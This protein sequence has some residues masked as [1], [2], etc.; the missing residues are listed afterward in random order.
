[1]STA[2]LRVA[3]IGGGI[4]G[5]TV[6]LAIAKKIEEG[7]NIQLDVYE[8]APKFAEIGAG[9]AF[10]PN[11]QRA[12]RL[13]GVGGALDAVAG[14]P[15]DDANLWFE[16]RVGDSGENSGKHFATITGTD[17]ARGSVHRAD[18]LDQLIKRL[19]TDTPNVRT[20]FN[21][22]ASS[23]T[24]HNDG[25][26]LHFER[27]DAE[28]AEVDLVIGSD[29]IKSLLRGHLYTRKGLDLDP[30]RARY[31]EWVAWRGL[32]SKETFENVFGPSVSNKTMH[33]GYGRHILH[34]PVR[35]GAL[36]NIVAFVRDPDHKKLG[37]HSGPWSEPRPKEEM[38]EDF[39]SFNEQ[40]RAL[41]GA[42]DSPSIW[43]IF[44]LPPIE[45]IVDDGVVLIGDAASA[46]TPHCGAGAGQAV[47]SALYLAAV[48]AHPSILTAPA[49]SRRA[50]LSR[51]LEVYKSVR[52]PRAQKVQI[53]SDKGGKLYEFLGP[54]GDDL[55][56]MKETLES[57]MSWIWEHDTEREMQR[58]VQMLDE[59]A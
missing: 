51:A 14:P 16:Y 24:P 32:I 47:E 54:E 26:T 34:F 25:V 3:V 33:C 53:E 43:G 7:A 58:M 19:P 55:G 36:V 37:N 1:M 6:A 22:R 57:R 20:H 59:Q 10:G 27:E 46:T 41:L 35:N 42:I 15:G 49:S 28:P 45:H 9:V 56:K 39:A 18:F 21:H 30:Q 29:G 13:I 23:Y 31:S 17:A 40:C 12:L 38:L 4:A 8:Q 50:A 5:L 11:A 48:L 2:P 44:S 52:H